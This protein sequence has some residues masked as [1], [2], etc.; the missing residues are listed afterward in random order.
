MKKAWAIQEETVAHRRYLHE[1]AEVGFDTPLTMDYID[2]TLKGYG[3]RPKRLPK[4]GIIAEIGKKEGGRDEFILLRA[5]VDGLKMVERSGLPFACKTGHMHA[6]GHDFHASSLL[7]AAKLL[8]KERL[9]NPVR[10]LFQPA[11]EVLEGAKYALEKGVCDD[12]VAAF[13]LHVL[14]GVDIPVGKVLCAGAGVL[15]PSA[16]TFEVRITGKGCHGATPY[17]GVDSL[18]TATTITQALIEMIAKEIPIGEGLLTIGKL[19]GASAPN[20]ISG[21]VI[22]GG[23][24]RAFDEEVRAFIKRR[25]A[26]IA[27]GIATA[28]RAQAKVRFFGGCPCLVQDRDLLEKTKKTFCEGLGKEG[29]ISAAEDGRKMGAS[30]DF[31][32][33]SAAVPSVLVSVSAA[34]KGGGYP[35]HHPKVVFDERALPTCVA[36][37]LAFATQK[38]KKER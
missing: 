14:S 4:G 2:K 17:Q 3:Y 24:C 25:V 23:S 19:E 27:K 6:C 31:A 34:Q 29:I 7:S 26:Q 13:S 21:E 38:I 18:A 1:R 12:V 36:S 9:S 28:Y 5:D 35:L 10:L 22:V 15:A 32:Y 33:I 16:D 30:E 11:E 20:V 8:I 37:Y